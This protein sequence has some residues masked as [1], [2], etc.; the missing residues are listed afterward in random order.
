MKGK[1]NC[2]C[3]WSWN[4]SDSS[5][6]DMYI[7]HECGRDNSNNM[8]NGG[9]IPQAQDG[10]QAINSRQKRGLDLLIKETEK[11]KEDEKELQTTG[12]IKNPKSIKYKKQQEDLNKRQTYLKEE[13][14]NEAQQQYDEAKGRKKEFKKTIKPI[15]QAADVVTD[16]MQLGNF[17][18]HPIGQAIGEVGNIAGAGIDAYQAAD[19]FSEGN[20]GS[21]AINAGSIFLP[22]V[23]GSQTF[24]RNSKYLQPGQPLYP[25]SPQAR[26][27]FIDRAHYIEPFNKVKGMTDKSLLANRALLGTLAAETVY[28]T[29]GGISESNDTPTIQYYNTEPK[30][31]EVEKPGT[32]SNIQYVPISNSQELKR[33]KQQKAKS[34]TEF[35]EF[36]K[37]EDIYAFEGK[38]SVVAK[39]GGW[40]DNYNDYKV[41][42]PEGM[43]G[44]GFSNV[45]R[46]YSPAW[47]GQFQMGG[48]IYPVNYVPQ[49]QDGTEL[50]EYDIA[51]RG[52]MK[53]KIGMGNAFGHPAIKRMSQAMPKTGMTPEGQ[54]THYMSSVDNYAV[55]LLQDLGEEELTLLDPDSRSREAIR[56]NSPEEAEYFAEHYKEVAPMS[57]IYKD[58]NSFQTGGSI[59]GAVG[60]SYARIGAPS[61]GP[62]RNQTDV[63]DASAQNGKEM[64]YYREGLDWK[65]KTISREG[66]IIK[67]D[68]G[69]WAHP[70]EITEINSPYI[71]M[72]GVPYPV[73]G[74]SDTGD[75]QMMYPEEEYEFDGE[76]VTEYPMAKNGKRQEQKG[77]VNL[78]QLT[79][80]S[81]YNTK[82][83]GGWLDNL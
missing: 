51:M 76:K 17:V 42:A 67:D 48:N 18:P 83:K 11:A 58:L 39:N 50:S 21:A 79:N 8:K 9:D 13:T 12:Q 34:P 33:W 3:G 35:I 43:V 59:P 46:N 28:D 45:G 73:L 78:D 32:E 29:F 80:W 30:R 65:P 7:C 20:Y 61:K 4:K 44:D 22:M 70:G 49:A 23:L 6:K 57:T 69:Q 56:F 75:M 1:V 38:K 26:N 40:L 60:F 55:P 82:Q 74:I 68:R 10:L 15:I 54:G 53:S 27:N 52:M 36:P 64:Q 19:D 16:I 2:T 62:R 31:G 25:F 66:S 24:R 41:S 63:T 47:G 5:K 37:G 72:K 77:L 14:R 81:N 71:T